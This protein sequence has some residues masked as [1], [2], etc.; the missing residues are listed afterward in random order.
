MSLTLSE[1]N[2]T[3][4]ST[5]RSVWAPRPYLEFYGRQLRGQIRSPQLPPESPSK[6]L[7][8]F[9]SSI[10]RILSSRGFTSEYAPPHN[11]EQQNHSLCLTDRKRPLER[12]VYILV[13]L[14]FESL[15][16]Q[17][18]PWLEGWLVASGIGCQA[19]GCIK[20]SSRPGLALA[21]R[22]SKLL[23][24]SSPSTDPENIDIGD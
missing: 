15:S 4:A 24:S 20:P 13:Y 7:F 10:I 12:S 11:P 18:K 22:A 19:A 9:F 21:Q 8:H 16:T 1:L 17:Q 6:I 2:G 23:H 3:L 5:S 14:K